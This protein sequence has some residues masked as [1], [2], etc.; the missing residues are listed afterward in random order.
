M[1]LGSDGFIAYEKTA[2]GFINRQHFPAMTINPLDVT[3]A[4]DSLISAMAVSL[5][6]GSTL[7]EAAAIGA[8]IAA[9]SVRSVGNLPI[10]VI[11]LKQ[12]LKEL[13]F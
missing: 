10:D 13:E 7:M 3:G 4:G 12:Q 8:Q 1:K 9:I 2:S 5:S 6:S 11:K